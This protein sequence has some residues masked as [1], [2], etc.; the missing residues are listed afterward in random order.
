MQ[1][2]NGL[3]VGLVGLG[4]MGSAIVPHLLRGCASVTL[5]NRSPG[6]SSEL[7][8]AGAKVAKSLDGVAQASDVVLSILLNDAAVEEVYLGAQGLLAA[9]CAGRVYVEMSTIQPDTIRRVAAAASARGAAL[10]DAPVSGSV[11]PARE[12]KL[13]VLAGGSAAD[14]EQVRPVLELFSRRIVHTGPSASGATMKLAVQLPIYVYWQALG[15]A[16]GIGTRAGLE[17]GDMLELIADSPAALPMLKAK[18]PVIRGDDISVAFALS[19]ARKDLSVIAAAAKSLGVALHVGSATLASY[20]AATQDG[21]GEA[22]VARLVN[23]LIKRADK[24]RISNS[25]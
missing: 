21:W 17:L 14:V 12:G 8:A 13:L 24:A 2:N 6:R 10:V 4:R 15:E 5:W 18:V 23:F 3:R 7:E 16:L 1:S 19:A 22:D 25:S 9:D 11:E 20:E